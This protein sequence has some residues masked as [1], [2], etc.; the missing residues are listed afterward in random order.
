MPRYE[1]DG[2]SLSFAACKKHI[3]L[4]FD[5]EIPENAKLQ[6]SGLI[7]RKN[8]LYLPFDLELP[9]GIIE[10]LAKQNFGV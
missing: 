8:A 5:P 3:S 2:R 9:G 4:Y 7:T 1:K 10:E 6:W